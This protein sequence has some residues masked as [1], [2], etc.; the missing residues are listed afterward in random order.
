MIY[1]MFSKSFTIKSELELYVFKSTFVMFIYLNVDLG[2]NLFYC[3]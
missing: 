2:I 3:R 1:N